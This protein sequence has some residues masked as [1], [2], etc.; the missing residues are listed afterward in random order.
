MRQRYVP[1]AG[2]RRGRASAGT[3]FARF[4][5]RTCRLRIIC[6][7]A[8]LVLSASLDPADI[9]RAMSSGAADALN[10]TAELDQLV[11][12]VRRLH[13]GAPQRS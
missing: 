7:T 3:L 5:G 13:R 9:T 4:C 8:A 12:A 11:D 6:D 10:K 1:S 2:V